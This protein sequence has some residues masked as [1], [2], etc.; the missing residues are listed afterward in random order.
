MKIRELLTLD[1]RFAASVGQRN[2]IDI[3][4]DQEEKDGK[5][6]NTDFYAVIKDDGTKILFPRGMFISVWEK[7]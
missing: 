2:V 4:V 3:Y 5:K 6:I 7:D 1:N